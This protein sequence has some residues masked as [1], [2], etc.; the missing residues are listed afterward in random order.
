MPELDADAVTTSDIATDHVLDV[1]TGEAGEVASDWM[2]AQRAQGVRRSDLV[3]RAG[4]QGADATVRRCAG[5]G[6]GAAGRVNQFDFGDEEWTNLRAVLAD[7][8]KDRIE[9]GVTPGEMAMFVLALKGRSS[10]GFGCA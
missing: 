7:V 8:T 9:R 2:E 10:P 5:R 3:Q 6:L 4:G 1:L